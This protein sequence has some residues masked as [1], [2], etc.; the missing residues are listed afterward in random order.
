MKN[1]KKYISIILPIF[2]FSLLVVCLVSSPRIVS[3][4]EDSINV[5]VLISDDTDSDIGPI[6]SKTT[7]NE[8]E[9]GEVTLKKEE[10]DKFLW[11]CTSGGETLGCAKE[12]PVCSTTTVN[13]CSKGYSSNYNES[14]GEWL[15]NGSNGN[16]TV[17]C[18]ITTGEKNDK[19]CDYPEADEYVDPISAYRCKNG[20]AIN[21][22][23]NE[24]TNKYEWTCLGQNGEDSF[25]QSEY[26]PYAVCG[27]NGDCLSGYKSDEVKIND[28]LVSWKCNGSNGNVPETVKYDLVY[29]NGELV[30]NSFPFHNR[31]KTCYPEKEGGDNQ[32]NKNGQCGDKVG[33]CVV[34]TPSQTTENSETN[35]SEWTCYGLGTGK[36]ALCQEEEDEEPEEPLTPDPISGKCGSSNG[37]FFNKIPTENLCQSGKES[38]VY[39]EGE[40]SWSWTCSGLY[41]GANDTCKTASVSLTPKISG[42][43]IEEGKSNCQLKDAFS[44]VVSGLESLLTLSSNTEVLN[45]ESK[46]GNRL[47]NINYPFSDIVLK[48]DNTELV[49]SRGWAI[50]KEGLYWDNQLKQ[51]IEPEA[52]PGDPDYETPKTPYWKYDSPS[53]C[54]EGKI[55]LA[56]ECINYDSSKDLYCQDEHGDVYKNKTKDVTYNCFENPPQPITYNIDFSA[57]KLNGG[58]ISEGSK[59]T[60]KSFFVKWNAST[61]PEG[62]FTSC[63]DIT[64][65]NNMYPNIETGGNI[66]GETQSIN[67]GNAEIDIELTLTCVKRNGG[68]EQK[69]IT[70]YLGKVDQIISEI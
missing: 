40:N 65:N 17:S 67:I 47:L 43:Y 61:E 39:N 62:Y 4:V 30:K 68:T 45:L 11:N 37:L 7:Y 19:E 25:C 6:C 8:C 53:A 15:C 26:Y 51:C 21:Q 63:L 18:K 56:G 24:S 28:E 50:C 57:K 64:I 42:C 41:G 35:L 32:V 48:T 31:S 66:N 59:V 2:A 38:G 12:K 49:R 13:G 60:D 58:N 52:C 14:T 55:T 9:K 10:S 54:I 20:Q 5:N 27:S 70:V 34:G 3:A 33:G 36:S 22:R 69:M 16:P 46:T 23:L 44:W 1:S 29:Q